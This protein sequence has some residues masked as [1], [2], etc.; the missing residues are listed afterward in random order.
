MTC[1]FRRSVELREEVLDEQRDVRPALAERRQTHR[2]H[3]QAVEQICAERAV[4]DQLLQVAIGGRDEANVDVD[5]LDSADA[6]ELALLKGAEELHLH[7]D[8][9]LADLVEEQRAAVRELETAGFARDR[10]R[11][12]AALVAEKLALDELLRNG[13]AIPL[14]NG[15]SFRDE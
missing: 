8:R 15:L 14:M 12:R 6:L 13:R 5:R 1:F 11:E 10:A 2:N 9:D 7:L 3:V 4:R